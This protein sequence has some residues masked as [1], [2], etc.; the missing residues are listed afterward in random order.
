MNFPFLCRKKKALI[1]IARNTLANYIRN[2][3]TLRLSRTSSPCPGNPLRCFCYLAKKRELRGCTDDLI[4]PTALEDSSG[5]DHASA[6]H[7][8][9]FDPVD[10]NELK[11]IDMRYPS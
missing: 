8:Y 1:S 10:R 4:L 2:G 7:D 11:E 9:R 3:K 6:V 5:N